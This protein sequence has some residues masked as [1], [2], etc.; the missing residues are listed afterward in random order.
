MDEIFRLREDRRRSDRATRVQYDPVALNQRHQEII[1]LAALGIPNTVIAEALCVHP[2]TVSN[3]VNS[4]LGKEKLALIRG[5]RD[6]D[7]VDIAKKMQEMIP[8]ALEVYEKIL[9]EE[10]MLGQQPHGGA[11]IKLQEKTAT[12]VLR[13]FSGL[14]VPKKM[15][16]GHAH[17][18]PEL[19]KEIKDQGRAAAKE[20]GLMDIINPEYTIEGEQ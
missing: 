18:T 11:D 12:S 3:A 20:C 8:K 16:V 19:L 4:T 6:A 1:N 10:A 14:A 15:V 2:A 9:S 17:L 13:D 7:T 5:A